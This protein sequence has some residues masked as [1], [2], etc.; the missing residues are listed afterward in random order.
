MFFALLY[1]FFL[2]LLLPF[3]VIFYFVYSI[4]KRKSFAH[5]IKR[6]FINYNF[7]IK[8]SKPVVLINAVSVGELQSIEFLL[9]KLKERGLYIVL[10]TTTKTGYEL[11]NR[12][13]RDTADKITLFPFDFPFLIRRFIKSVN[14][15]IVLSVEAEFWFNFFYYLKRK[16]I[17]LWIVNMRVSNERM[18]RVFKFY[19]KKVFSIPEIFFVPHERYLDFLKDF[20]VSS[21]KIVISG[22]LKV[23][24]KDF[25]LQE[26]TLSKIKKEVNLSG[27][28][29]LFILGST[30]EGEEELFCKLFFDFKSRWKFIVAPRNI[31][32]AKAIFNLLKGCGLKVSLRT[33][34]V[35]D[36]DVL[37]VDTI[38]ELIYFYALS[39]IAFVGGS[40]VKKGGHNI[41]EP[42]SVGKLTLTGPYYYNFSDVVKELK[43]K[44][45][46]IVINRVD[47]IYRFLKLSKEKLKKI[48]KKAREKLETL[49]GTTDLIVQYIEKRLND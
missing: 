7:K 48:G 32:R 44:N 40:L 36:F 20:G 38:G 39:D 12:K 1:N 19:Y 16:G 14:P 30:A 26:S 18:Y 8:S 33:K 3:F 22:N 10:S 29:K 13:Y 25:K 23:D 45:A 6:I 42:I 27:N 41:L 35:K 5:H 49:S 4:F 9:K 11:A 28:E 2:F 24:I 37:I 34:A 31:K 15:S 47:D 43:D 21:K 17:P 46:L